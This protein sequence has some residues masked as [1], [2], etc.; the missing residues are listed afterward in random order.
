MA[1]AVRSGCDDWAAVPGSGVL[2]QEN[3]DRTTNSAR[4]MYR[5]DIET[6]GKT[7]F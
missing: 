6:S 2:E 3:A 4:D 1:M 5:Q 7:G